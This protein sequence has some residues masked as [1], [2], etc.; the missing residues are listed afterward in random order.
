MNIP[1]QAIRQINNTF[2]LNVDEYTLYSIEQSL[3]S[4]NKHRE[5]A[6]NIEAK[7]SGRT[8]KSCIPSLVIQRVELPQ[9][10]PSPVVPVPRTSPPLNLVV[11]RPTIQ[12]TPY[13]LERQIMG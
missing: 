13:N 3:A 11:T 2:T 4:T 12:C 9:P 5:T 8:P 10:I 6:R 7:K 1:I